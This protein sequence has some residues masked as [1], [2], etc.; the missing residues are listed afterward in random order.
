MS[1]S[2][3]AT[4][5]FVA[6]TRKAK[7]G[8]AGCHC[9]HTGAIRKAIKNN[10]FPLLLLEDDAVP[11]GKPNLKQLFDSAPPTASLLYFGA[12]PVKNRKRVELPCSSPGW[13]TPGD[14][15][16]YGG[17]AYG[18]RTKEDAEELLEF[19]DKNRITYDSALVKW[20]KANKS[21]VAV[22]CPFQFVQSDGYSDIEGVQRPLR[23]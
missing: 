17:H 11:V 6:K 14:E 8:R 3:L 22:Y 9:S 16:L 15:T 13:R 19:L 5:K 21:R 23:G 7:A 1:N 12:L 18:F 2:N 20:T 10:D 4:Y